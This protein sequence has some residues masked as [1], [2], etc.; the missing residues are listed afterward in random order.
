MRVSLN[1]HEFLHLDG[2]SLRHA[3][4][5]V[6]TE[7][8]EHDVFR[9]LL[10]VGQ[11]VHLER[12]ILFLRFTSHARPRERTVHHRALLVHAAQNL[13]TRRD[14]H[15][16]S[17]LV[18]NHVRRGVHDAQRPVHLERVHA[19]L[20]LKSMAEH[21]LENITRLDV[22]L[23]RRHRAQ[24]LILRHRTILRLARSLVELQVDVPLLQIRQLCRM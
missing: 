3:S 4:D 22:F 23:R 15:A 19:R 18:I 24:E 11:E 2:S 13:R 8:D 16:I 12:L 20:T 9:A 7:V 17:T 21:E 10:F 1:L 5:V 14:Q 6:A